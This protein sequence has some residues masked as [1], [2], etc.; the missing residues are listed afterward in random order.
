[1]IKCLSIIDDTTCK[2]VAIKVVGS[3][4]LW[5]TATECKPIKKANDDIYLFVGAHDLNLQ[6]QSDDR[7]SRQRVLLLAL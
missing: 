7:N 5:Q 3:D 2:V 1:M 4:R 6:P